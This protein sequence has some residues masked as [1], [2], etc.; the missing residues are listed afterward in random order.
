M[1]PFSN[2]MYNSLKFIAQ[3]L[4]PGGGALYFAV[5]QIWGL[6]KAEEVVGT[7]T[8]IDVFL[9]LI[10]EWSTRTYNNSDAKYDGAIVVEQQPN[11]PK[12]FNLELS[13]DPHDLDQ[14]K[15]VTFKVKPQ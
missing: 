8:A 15:E 2:S 14:K 7:V 3:I 13:S 12:M 4:L 6:P 1:P 5:A 9:G 10:L 11:G